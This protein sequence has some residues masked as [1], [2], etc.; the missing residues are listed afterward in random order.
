MHAPRSL[1]AC[2]AALLAGATTGCGGGEDRAQARGVVARFQA[3]LEGDRPGIACRQ[4][5]AAARAQLEEQAGSSCA[6][7]LPE[8][9]LTPGAVVRVEVFVTNAKVDAAG[10]DSAFLDR[11][12]TGWKLSAVGCRAVDGKPRDRPLDCALKA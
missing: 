1:I 8:L 4:L 6:R 10:G 7:A 2:C 5:S 3:A 9:G 11:E 12:P